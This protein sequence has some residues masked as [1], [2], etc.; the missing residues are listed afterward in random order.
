[1]FKINLEGVILTKSGEL[2]GIQITKKG[3]LTSI[4]LIKFLLGLSR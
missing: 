4:S 1:M 2:F 3:S